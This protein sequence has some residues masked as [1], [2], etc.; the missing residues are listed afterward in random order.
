LRA[1]ADAIP[2]T[3]VLGDPLQAI[4]GLKDTV[5]VTWETTQ[6]RFPDHP[7]ETT[8]WRWAGHNEAL[9]A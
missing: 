2:A 4:F 7:I 8:A 1:L 5:L 3:G 9:G 6:A